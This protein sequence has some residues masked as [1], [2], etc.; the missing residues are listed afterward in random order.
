MIAITPAQLQQLAPKAID[1]YRTAFASADTALVPYGINDTALRLAHFMAQILHESGALTVRTENLNY[2][3]ER[4][5]QVWPSRFPTIDAAKPYEHNPE[6]LANFVYGGRMGNV[7]PGDGWKFIGR[8]L[9]QITGRSSYEK[10]GRL[11][12]VDLANNPDFAFNGDWAL[13]LAAEEW[14]AGNCNAK[15]DADDIVGVT[16]IINGGTIGLDDRKAWL[17]KC[18]VIWH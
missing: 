2:R 15:A 4:L 11:L 14:K 16:K 12:G 1:T 17:A 18:K 8:G 13:K 5:I 6:K 9:I 7:N 3:A 10:F